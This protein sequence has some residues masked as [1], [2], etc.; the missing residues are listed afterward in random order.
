MLRMTCAALALVGLSITPAASQDASPWGTGL[1]AAA[2]LIAGSFIKTDD[3]TILRA[4][5]EIRLD[6]GWHTYWRDPGNSGVPPT[7]DFA[8]SEN[9]K[10]V[11]VL[12]PAPARF[13]D[14]C[15][16]SFYWLHA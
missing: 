9:I 4:G 14:R 11:T 15:R 2:R 5:V 6:P 3:A 13:P 10:S 1:H 16:R 12:W 8:G 7:F